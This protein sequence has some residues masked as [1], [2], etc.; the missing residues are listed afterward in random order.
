MRTCD[1]GLVWVPLVNFRS[2]RTFVANDGLGCRVNVCLVCIDLSD[3]GMR[4]Y[5]R[6]EYK[7]SIFE[8]RVQGPRRLKVS[9]TT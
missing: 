6:Y 8:G 2:R 3:I 5:A 4:I 1:E 7:W 9:I